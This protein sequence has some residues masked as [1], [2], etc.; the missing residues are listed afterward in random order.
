M[1]T[2]VIYTLKHGSKFSTAALWQIS[3]LRL[4]TFESTHVSFTNFNTHTHT[5]A[6]TPFQR[7][8]DTLSQN[9]FLTFSFITLSF[10]LSLSLHLFLSPFSYSLHFPFSLYIS[11]PLS[12]SSFITFSKSLIL[13]F[14]FSLSTSLS[15]LLSL[16]Q[17]LSFFLSH[18]LY[19]SF[20]HSFLLL[21]SFFILTFPLL[22]LSLHL[23]FFFLFLTLF[24]FLAEKLSTKNEKWKLKLNFKSRAS[25]FWQKCFPTNSAP[26]ATFGH[27][28]STFALVNCLLQERNNNVVVVAS[29]SWLYLCVV[30]ASNSSVF[31]QSHLGFDPQQHRRK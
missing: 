10:F 4:Q 11:L 21:S 8:R 19:I 23:P 3:L 1:S 6:S 24:N 15:L 9:L 30:A 22:F 7:K 27:F 26:F 25:N 17:N 28:K 18:Y 29:T 14:F 2:N 31:Y 12:L 13:S 5:L 20:S 16:S